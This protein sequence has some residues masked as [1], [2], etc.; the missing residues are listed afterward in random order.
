VCGC[1]E[2]ALKD[3]KDKLELFSTADTLHA[4]KCSIRSHPL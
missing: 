2:A 3:V 4:V 1:E